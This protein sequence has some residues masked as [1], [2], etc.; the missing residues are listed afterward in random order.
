MFFLVNCYF[1]ADTFSINKPNPSRL[2]FLFLLYL[3]AFY[4]FFLF[5]DFLSNYKVCLPFSL[6]T[7]VLPLFSWLFFL[8]MEYHINYYNNITN[9][10]QSLKLFWQGSIKSVTI[11]QSERRELNFK[12]LCIRSERKFKATAMAMVYID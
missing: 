11:S 7:F 9:K 10:F 5:T 12:I 6:L 2:S 4:A 8:T 1:V 3:S